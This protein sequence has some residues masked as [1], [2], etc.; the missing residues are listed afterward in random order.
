MKKA[1]RFLALLTAM[2][3]TLAFAIPTMAADTYTLTINSADKSENHQ[4]Y[5]YQIFKGTLSND[6]KTLSDVEW[7]DGVQTNSTVD[8]KTL[9]T[10]IKEISLDD[11]TKPFEN[12]SDIATA[13][14]VAAILN[15]KVDDSEIAKAFAK[16]VS[17]Y[18]SAVSQEVPY[19]TGSEGKYVKNDLA[20]GYYLI[21]DK[22][23]TVQDSKPSDLLLKLVGDVTIDAKVDMATVSK[24]AGNEGKG[25]NTSYGIGD[26]I[27]YTLKGTLPANYEV[28]ADETYQYVFKD[29][30]SKYLELT[31]Y[32]LEQLADGGVS[33]TVTSGVTVKV[34]DQDITASAKI[35][36]EENADG[37]SVLTITFENLYD[38]TAVGAG[39][40]ITVEYNAKLVDVPTDGA[41]VSNHV[42]LTYDNNTS[43]PEIEEKV[44]PVNL[45][46]NKTDKDDAKLAGA[47]FE[48]YRTSTDNGAG[49]TEYLVV[50]ADGAITWSK[51]ESDATTLVTD[52]N[53]QIKVNGLAAGT[54]YLKETKAPDGYNQL[55]NPVEMVI[56]AAIGVNTTSGEQELTA[57]SI[58]VD[59]QEGAADKTTGTVTATIINNKGVTLPSTGGIGTTI[60]YVIG[61]ILVIGAAVVL[62]V[63]RRMNAE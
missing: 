11:N 37:T 59:G 45:V 30:M 1:K 21:Q 44:F 26:I 20:A 6:Q 32:T 19:V 49:V 27:K 24:S 42:V 40:V 48:L 17:S 38:V 52:G 31:G 35:T 29:T 56:G 43:T 50:G 46:I 61:G 28:K 25:D 12:L 53:G 47:E 10:A 7:G 18:L 63:R 39:S 62:I 60:F 15:G 4:F 9:L 36:Y 54:Y 16:T 33:T 55:E 23:T 2:V 58:T 3:M 41:G 22:A 5:A 13:A 8:G 51:T 34:G 57:L 14:D